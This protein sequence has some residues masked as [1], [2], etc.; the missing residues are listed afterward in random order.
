M[1]YVG[2]Q[3]PIYYDQKHIQVEKSND[4]YSKNKRA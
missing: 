3:I 2:Q 1:V 4:K